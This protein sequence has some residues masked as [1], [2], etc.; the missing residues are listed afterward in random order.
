M[1]PNAPATERNREPI[2]SVLQRVLPQPGRVL[3]I[4]SGT[5]QHAAY[6]GERLPQVVWQA[7]D[8]AEN[9]PG[10]RLWLC[11]AMLPNVPQPR[12]LDVSRFSERDEF[13]AVFSANTLHIMSWDDV[14][15]MFAG[16]GN[17]LRDGGLLIIYGPFKRDGHISAPSN[18][19][20]DASLRAQAPHMGLRDFADVDRLARDAGLVF[21]CAELMPANNEMLVW[22]MH[23]E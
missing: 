22:R 17:T 5:G 21:E 8:R 12:E 9:L 7:S 18:R 3:E 1:K 20:F 19:A 16:I 6:F 15:C 11:E 14:C 13:D 4:G 23:D 10:I 2:L